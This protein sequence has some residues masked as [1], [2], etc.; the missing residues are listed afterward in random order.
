MASREDCESISHSR[1]NA[2]GILKGEKPRPRFLRRFSPLSRPFF[3]SFLSATR[4]KW[5]RSQVET[6]R[7]GTDCSK[8]ETGFFAKPGIKKLAN[9]RAGFFPWNPLFQW[10]FRVPLSF[11][12]PKERGERKGDSRGKK[13]LGTGTQVFPPW[14][15]PSHRRRAGERK[16]QMRKINI[17]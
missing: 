4:K 13:T 5:T 12:S 8:A 16:Q 17:L 9:H 11:A 3:G 10:S 6:G 1:L 14:K 15:S 2:R 7:K